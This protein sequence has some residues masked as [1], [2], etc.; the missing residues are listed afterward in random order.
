MTNT[1]HSSQQADK[2]SRRSL[3]VLP[4]IRK[5]LVYHGHEAA[6]YLLYLRALFII[7]LV[8]TIA[9]IVV[10]IPINASLDSEDYADSWFART[11]ALSVYG[12]DRLSRYW[13]HAIALVLIACT[14]LAAMMWWEMH[15][16][17][18]H[19]P[20]NQAIAEY[21]ERRKRRN[22]RILEWREPPAMTV[23]VGRDDQPDVAGLDLVSP[24]IMKQRFPGFVKTNGSLSTCSVLVN[25]LPKEV[26]SDGQLL[27]FA[28]KL[29]PN[30]AQ[31]DIVSCRMV[32]DLRTLLDQ[33]QLVL[34]CNRKMTL[35]EGENIRR[36]WNAVRL[37][38]SPESATRVTTFEFLKK[39]PFIRSVDAFDY[40]RNERTKAQAK[41]REEDSKLAKGELVTDRGFIVF[42]N[43][44]LADNVI[45]EKNKKGVFGAVGK[46][47]G[48]RFEYA[49][50]PSDVQWANLPLTDAQRWGRWLAVQGCLVLMLIF[51][52]SPA[53]LAAILRIYINEDSLS[54][55]PDF[56]QSLFFAY[57]P[58][59]LLLV[60][61]ILIPLI[62]IALTKQE[63]QPTKSVENRLILLRIYTY[64]VLSTLLIPTVAIAI[65]S[66]VTG[67]VEGDIGGTDIPRIRDAFDTP[68]QV[69][70]LSYLLQQALVGN[71]LELLRP[72]DLILKRV[73]AS[74]TPM[75]A[76]EAK[77]QHERAGFAFLSSIA[78]VTSVV[79]VAIAF[80][81]ITPLISVVGLFFLWFRRYVDAHNLQYVYRP[82][83]RITLQ[84]S[85]AMYHAKLRLIARIATTT[86]IF[87]AIFMF[88]FFESFDAY[89]Q[90]LFS[91]AVFGLLVL[92]AVFLYGYR[93]KWKTDL[94]ERKFASSA[95]S[96]V[97]GGRTGVYFSGLTDAEMRAAYVCP[98]LH[99]RMFD[100]DGV[101]LERAALPDRV[102]EERDGPE[103]SFEHLRYTNVEGFKPRHV[104]RYVEGKHYE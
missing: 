100:N 55:V 14:T 10:L 102:V 31:D 98:L 57:L 85:Y 47:A 34:K 45:H 93:Y 41:I 77:I 101:E 46:V 84:E 35:A 36:Q 94:F 103:L 8:T 58:S 7:M 83:E 91:L 60:A 6:I 53:A 56:I 67:Y 81:L 33:E 54:F 96:P 11:S 18:R 27:E 20:S 62:I 17:V 71:I 29:V 104:V 89:A 73:L 21:G 76:E 64:L 97:S 86:T 23:R 92:A 9:A 49:P 39:L 48:L 74:K 70:F 1:S 80:S 25:G 13:A 78:S 37:A 95:L 59:I 69:F 68:V 32:Q 16:V 42:R 24:G 61:A 63:R 19:P 43:K 38:K 99:K 75:S 15:H 5:V 79:A 82:A 52:S 51:A 88:F 87:L 22:S 90:S 30:A 12:A 4:S 40:W 72:V 3:F 44:A 28:R 2:V 65:I 26:R 50:E 66:L